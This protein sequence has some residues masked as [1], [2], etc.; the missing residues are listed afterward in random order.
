MSLYHH[1]RLSNRYLKIACHN[2]SQ[3]HF[4]E[5]PHIPTNGLNIAHHPKGYEP[6]VQELNQINAPEDY[7]RN[8]ACQRIRLE[9]RDP[10]SLDEKKKRLQSNVFPTLPSR[11]SPSTKKRRRLPLL[12][13][14]KQRPIATPTWVRY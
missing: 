7:I 4:S 3:N 2:H 14:E 6:F 5:I 8:E 11:G 1:R 12:T 9:Y 10:Q 13:P